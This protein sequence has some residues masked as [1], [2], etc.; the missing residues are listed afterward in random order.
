MNAAAADDD[1]DDDASDDDDQK[2]KYFSH[3]LTCPREA[4]LPNNKLEL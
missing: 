2:F 3:W 4:N 1:D